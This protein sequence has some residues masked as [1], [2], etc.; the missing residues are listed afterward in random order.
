MINHTKKLF[1]ATGIGCF[2]L[3]GVAQAA[4]SQFADVSLPA[5]GYS[6][7]SANING[8]AIGEYGGGLNV[9]R[10]K[11]KVAA[12]KIVQFFPDSTVSSFTSSSTT[13]ESYQIDMTPENNLYYVQLTAVTNGPEGYGYIKNYSS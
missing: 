5:L 8:N 2:L 13:L 4:S 1:V 3:A 6:V 10:G 9:D 7:S 11:M 12:K